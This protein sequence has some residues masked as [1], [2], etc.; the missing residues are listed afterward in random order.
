[1]HIAKSTFSSVLGAT[2][3]PLSNDISSSPTA[4]AACTS[5]TDERT[6]EL[7]DHARITLVTVAGIAD[8]VSAMLPKLAAQFT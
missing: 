3:V 5:V 6:D 4:L 1:M 2:R 7:T 8:A